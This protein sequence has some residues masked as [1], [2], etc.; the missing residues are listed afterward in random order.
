MAKESSLQFHSK[1][2]GGQHVVGKQKYF[3]SI[4]GR[5]YSGVWVPYLYASIKGGYAPEPMSPEETLNVLPQYGTIR[6][7]P[8]VSK[9]QA[10]SKAIQKGGD[11]KSKEVNKSKKKGRS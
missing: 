4:L 6:R 2:P 3:R 10:G 5:V 1:K 7:A 11:R 8:S 9:R